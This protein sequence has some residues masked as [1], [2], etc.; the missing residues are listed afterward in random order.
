M[1]RK[2][3]TQPWKQW[4]EERMKFLQ[5]PEISVYTLLDKTAKKFPDHTAIIFEDN[6]IDYRNLKLRGRQ[7]CREMERVGFR[8]RR[9]NWS[10]DGQSSLFYCQLL[11][12]SGAWAYCCTAESNV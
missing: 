1:V 5:L 4:Y 6:L 8:E 10:D 7:T 3:V 2:T 9:T 11:R 12:C